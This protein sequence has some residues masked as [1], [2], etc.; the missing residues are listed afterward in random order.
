MSGISG[1]GTERRCLTDA[2]QQE[3]EKDESTAK[4]MNRVRQHAGYV[5]HDVAMR[6]DDLPYRQEKLHLEHGGKQTAIEAGETGSHV[7]GTTAELLGH[8]ALA[9]GLALGGAVVGGFLATWKIMEANEHGQILRETLAK[10]EMQLALVHTLDLPSGYKIEQNKLRPDSGQSAQSGSQRME[11]WLMGADRAVLAPL[12]RH[13]DDGMRAASRMFDG[14]MDK[15]AFFAQNP[16]ARRR[17]DEDP[18]FHHGFDA[19]VWAKEQ[20]DATIYAKTLD[21]LKLRGEVFAQRVQCKA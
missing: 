10:D 15:T 1:I 12:Q 7:I 2:E 13:C 20:K 18:A 16:E 21:D 8:G 3:I 17:Y 14:H 9:G 5:D 19:L 11:T 4:L 6:G